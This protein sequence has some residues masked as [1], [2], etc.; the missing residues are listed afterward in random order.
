MKILV[1]G[2]SGMLGYSLFKNLFKKSHLEVFGTI[3]NKQTYKDKF[4][5][6]EYDK[7]FELDVLADTNKIQSIVKKIQPDLL[8][9]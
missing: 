8:E 9:V 1:L 3:R 2:S 4:S 5:F 6:N 7:L